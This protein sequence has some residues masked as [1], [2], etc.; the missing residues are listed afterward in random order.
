MKNKFIKSTII[1]IVGGFFTKILGLI[2]RIVLTRYIGTKG[3]G[4]Y[5][6]LIPTFMLLNSIA[7]LGLPTALNVLISSEKYNNRNIVFTSICIS[8]LIDMIIL[9]VLVFNYQFLSFKLF[10]NSK[11]ALGL[12]SIGFILPFITISNALRSYFFAKQR[13]YP[14]VITNIIEDIIRLL[15]IVIGIPIIMPNGLEYVVAY[16]L[17]TNVFSELSSIIIFIILIPNFKYRKNELIPNKKNIKDLLTIALPTTGSRII[18]SI[19]YFFEPIIITYVLIKIGYDNNF[20]LREYGIING[21]VMQL[22]L[23]P[24][25]FTA[26]ISQALIPIVSKNYT[27]NNF[28][29]IKK[30]IKQAIMVSLLIGIPMTLILEIYPDKLLHFLFKTKEGINYIRVIAPICILHYIQSP[31]SSS[32]QAMHASKISMKGT[33]FGMIFRTIILFIF[34]Y[35]KIGLWSLIIATSINIIFVTIYDLLNV[36]RILKTPLSKGY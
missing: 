11:L 2:I 34:S 27:N 26:A 10:N 33:L 24:S 15:L 20:I 32:L 14:H 29:Y 8:L 18:G 17:L 5:S 22:V 30:K 35:L 36:I 6:M 23:L 28:K 19:G 25:F 21:Y 4:M 3:I 31:I 9:M 13:M 12:L 16:V 1:L 7:G